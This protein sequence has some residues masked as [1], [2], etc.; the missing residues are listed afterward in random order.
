[1][2]DAPPT[3][4][5]P[6]PDRATVLG[7]MA[8]EKRGYKAAAAH[9]GM[10]TDTVKSWERREKESAARPAK[11]E[12]VAKG[13]KEKP[14]RAVV[15]PPVAPESR[16]RKGVLD[17]ATSPE[18]ARK[19]RR[20]A[21]AIADTLEGLAVAREALASAE[22]ERTRLRAA[23]TNERDIDAL[24]PLP[25]MPDMRQIESGARSLRELLIIAP[26]LAAFDAETGGKSAHGGPSAEE[27]E[28]AR[29]MMLADE[30]VAAPLA[31]VDGGRA[32]G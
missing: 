4:P 8:A 3:P 28:Q 12:V 22:A 23:G 2:S 27:R 18:M 7:W 17:L 5:A 14:A 11:T 25:T 32:R 20:G 30:L 10:S 1:M 13:A 31:V 21:W 16:T 15:A 9:F 29:R 6:L 26:G 24:A 19:L